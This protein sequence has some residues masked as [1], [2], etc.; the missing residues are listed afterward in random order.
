MDALQ[1]T[2]V[3][4]QLDHTDQYL[5]FI[6]G[7][8]EYGVE[9]LRVQEVKGWENVRKIPN[10]PSYI[11]GVINLRGAV[12]PIVCLRERLGMPIKTAANMTVVIVLRVI[13]EKGHSIMG[14]VADGV[15]E[16]Y[17]IEASQMQ[18][19]PNFGKGFDASFIKSVATVND[20]MI[21]LLDVDRLLYK[22]A[23]E[24][25]SKFDPSELAKQITK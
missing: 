19:P 11:K 5:T 13:T 17:N 24:D 3:S 22:S 6:M 4:R 9:I 20:K 10:L 14:V 8:E 21:V 7:N 15:S 2:A 25:L 18:P 16:V 12:V 23:Q 1:Q